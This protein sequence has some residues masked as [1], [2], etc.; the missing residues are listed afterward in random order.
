MRK[1]FLFPI[2]GTVIVILGIFWL[3]NRKAK[4]EPPIVPPAPPKS[5]VIVPELRLCQKDELINDGT[6]FPDVCRC[7]G[8][9]EETEQGFVCRESKG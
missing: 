4:I 1:P 6:V 7:E 9:V 3:A 5:Q 2:I 8:K